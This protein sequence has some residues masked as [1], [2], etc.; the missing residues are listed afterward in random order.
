MNKL[1]IPLLAVSVSFVNAQSITN[2]SFNKGK[3]LKHWNI[4]EEELERYQAYMDIEGK[5]RYPN[6]TPL[7]VLGITAESETQMQ[8]YA[9]KAAI[10]ERAQVKKEIK[11]AVMTTEYKKQMGELER[12]NDPEFQKLKAQYLEQQ[13]R[14]QKTKVKPLFKNGGSSPSPLKPKG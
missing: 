14:R 9:K 5:F 6:L 12:K 8:Y 11:F 1:A 13:K 3:F 4:T 2:T 7:E 10:N